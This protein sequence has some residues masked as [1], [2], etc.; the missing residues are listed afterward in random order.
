MARHACV[1]KCVRACI[2]TYTCKY[3]GVSYAQGK[4]THKPHIQNKIYPDTC[5]HIL[6]RPVLH[7]TISLDINQQGYRS[8]P[9]HVSWYSFSGL[10]IP[11]SHPITEDLHFTTASRT[12][13]GPALSGMWSVSARTRLTTSE[14]REKRTGRQHSSSL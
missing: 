11:D 1:C 10:Q 6:G 4:H 8:T 7:W 13:L 3:N 5:K 12:L 14:E 9:S 2:C